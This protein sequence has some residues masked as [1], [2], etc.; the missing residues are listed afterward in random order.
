MPKEAFDRNVIT[1]LVGINV[2]Q[3]N[4]HWGGKEYKMCSIYMKEIIKLYYETSGFNIFLSY[5]I[6]PQ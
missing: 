2:Y 4:V 3:H 1:I 6:F 5:L